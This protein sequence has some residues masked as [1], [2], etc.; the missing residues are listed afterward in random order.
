[1]GGV[2]E[3]VKE[4]KTRNSHLRLADKNPEFW[5]FLNEREELAQCEGGDE[6]QKEFANWQAKTPKAKVFSID[7]IFGTESQLIVVNLAGVQR[8]G[9][10]A[11]KKR[12]G[13]GDAICWVSNWTGSLESYVLAL[14]TT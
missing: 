8:S 3:A 1:M 12:S 10:R 13:K 9:P 11:S 2:E 6:L 5:S 7:S 14:P 4:L